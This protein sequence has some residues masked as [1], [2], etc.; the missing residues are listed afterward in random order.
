MAA[1]YLS[2]L[3]LTV[4]ALSCVHVHAAITWTS[5]VNYSYPLMPRCHT[6]LHFTTQSVK[7]KKEKSCR[8]TT[9]KEMVIH[10]FIE[11]KLDCQLG[12]Y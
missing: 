11:A 1:I 10:T 8:S 9:D 12:L 6:A 5:L 4:W 2:I 3:N 7:N